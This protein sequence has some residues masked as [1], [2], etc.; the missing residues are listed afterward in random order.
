MLLNLSLVR[1]IFFFNLSCILHISFTSVM[2]MSSTCNVTDPISV[3]G[4]GML[5]WY[6]LRDFF[7]LVPI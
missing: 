4:F 7:F 2:G 5:W 3:Q 6:G 1:Q